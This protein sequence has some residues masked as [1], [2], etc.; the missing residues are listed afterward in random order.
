MKF[1]AQIFANSVERRGAITFRSGRESPFNFWRRISLYSSY[2]HKVNQ[3]LYRV[4]QFF[5]LLIS[6]HIALSPRKYHDI[7]VILAI[8]IAEKNTPKFARRRS[9]CFSALFK[10]NF[11]FS[12]DWFVFSLSLFLSFGWWENCLALLRGKKSCITIFPLFGEGLSL[13]L[14]V[15]LSSFS[16]SLSFSFFSTHTRKR[17]RVRTRG[18]IRIISH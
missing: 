15:S 3:P 7:A 11:D 9:P 14:P 16:L 12:R 2:A 6:V 18:K 13:S 10:R 17:E 4:L 1:R 8:L 5:A